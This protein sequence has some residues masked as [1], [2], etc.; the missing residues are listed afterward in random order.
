MATVH[1]VLKGRPG[2]WCLE[3]LVRHTRDRAS[4]VIREL[5]ALAAR[6]VEGR[7]GTCAEVG[8]VFF[9]RRTK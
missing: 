9:S 1:E 6:I 3:C 2:A 7:C 4:D 8:P 5:D